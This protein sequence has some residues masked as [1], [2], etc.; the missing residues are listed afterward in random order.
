MRTHSLQLRLIGLMLAAV[1]LFGL[2]AGIQSYR[3][4]LH[5]ADEIFDAQLAQLGQT[6]LAVA[7]HADDD[8]T[9]STGPIAHKYQRSLAFQVWSTE[10]DQPRLL[11]HSGK[12]AAA[13]P[14]PLPEP[15]FSHGEWQGQRWRYYRQSDRKRELDVLVGQSDLARNDLAR[16]VAWHNLQ[17]FLFGL[18]LLAIAALIAIRLGLQ[19]LRKLAHEL[20]QRSPERL[21]PVRLADSPS[22]IAPVIEALDRLFVRVAGTLE[23]ER[24]FTS[25][26]AHEL[27]T[28]LAALRAQVQAA[29]LT[30]NSAEQR[31]SLD[32]ALLGTDRMNH[33][34]GQL[35]TLARLDELSSST[36][37]EP[38]DLAAVTRECCAELGPDALAKN[39]DLELKGE[40]SAPISGSPDLLRVLV[41]N[42]LDNAIRYTPVGGHIDVTI[43]FLK[44]SAYQL[45]VCDSGPGV[46]DEQL[47]LLGQRFSRFSPTLAEGVGLGLSIVLRIA[48]IHQA[49]IAFSRA[50]TAGGLRVSAEFPPLSH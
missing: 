10:H 47:A 3:N 12:S 48:E 31:E 38:V 18:P 27:R 39:V 50:T 44:N 19:P 35:L 43:Q 33:L 29:M 1:L 11:L 16:E 26:A 17:P 41:R 6:L 13:L 32:K 42:L 2:I 40:D 15:G 8:E 20:Q 46:P 25:D 4:A 9:A 7:I 21:D 37:L 23:N 28:P 5:E 24:R 22:E 14:D 36:H 30:E 49:R 34:V 45:E